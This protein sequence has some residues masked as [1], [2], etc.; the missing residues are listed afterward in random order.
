ML[1]AFEPHLMA[2]DRP[3]RHRLR[4]RPMAGHPQLFEMT[5]GHDGGG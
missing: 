3:F 5:W 4:V 1:E 2:P